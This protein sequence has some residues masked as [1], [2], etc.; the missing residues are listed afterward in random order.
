MCIGKRPL[1]IVVWVE[2]V[3]WPTTRPNEVVLKAIEKMQPQKKCTTIYLLHQRKGKGI[4][5][6]ESIEVYPRFHHLAICL[7][8]YDIILRIRKLSAKKYIICGSIAVR[9]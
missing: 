8:G 6:T 5:Q 9:C 3:P 4:L 2:R 1:L 7:P